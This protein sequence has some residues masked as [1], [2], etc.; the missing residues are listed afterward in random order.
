[1]VTLLWLSPA[2]TSAQRK[3]VFFESFRGPQNASLQRSIVAKVVDDTHFE[4]INSQKMKRFVR[5]RKAGRLKHDDYV[6][7]A[8]RY[9]ISAFVGGEV[10]KH[11]GGWVA[12]VEVKN[13]SDGAIVG[14]VTWRGRTLRDL[15][16]GTRGAA[17]KVRLYLL[18]TK[19]PPF[20]SAPVIKYKPPI[21][22]PPP[23]E[24]PPREPRPREPL[25]E[26]PS[27]DSPWVLE[28]ERLLQQTKPQPNP[29][30]RQAAER[31]K[32]KKDAR[33]PKGISVT[34]LAGVLSR[35]M[36][37]QLRV[38]NRKRTDNPEYEQ[39]TEQRTYQTGL[40][41]YP[42][43]GLHVEIYPGILLDASWLE[44]LG[45]VLSYRRGVLLS[46]SGCAQRE[47]SQEPCPDTGKIT[48]GT[49]ESEAYAGLKGRFLIP[50]GPRFFELSPEVGIG[51]F[52]YDFN[53]DDI[54]RLDLPAV[55]PPMIYRYVQLGFQV[56]YD[57]VARYF[58]LGFN[59]NYR[60]GLTNPDA[61][62]VWGVDT[63]ASRGFAVGLNI[64]S[65]APYLFDGAFLFAGGE[66][67]RFTTRFAGQA[68]CGQ[69]G[70]NCPRADVPEYQNNTPW[71]TFP[72]EQREGEATGKVTG[73]PQAPV[74]DTYIRIQ[75][76]LGW[77]FF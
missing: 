5:E 43:A 48:V 12:S 69:P 73:G 71:E 6:T 15:Q 58:N 40:P 21:E 76:G 50:D 52:R 34:L 24:P 3:R 9:G 37:G 51:E 26:H 36:V 74:N 39:I 42:E 64:R 23:R 53:L 75:L 41:G 13:G 72:E 66:W 22:E 20:A 55:I 44:P 28:D 61:N 19:P 46:S 57:F 33:K 65:E 60:P 77:A 49:L 35:D 7:F 45:V 29:L 14:V 27:G 8:K 70:G 17:D 16:T 47:N 4:R 11:R 59:F 31:P 62:L 1:V 2:A 63:K 67:F 56:R 30:V 38:Y 10:G 25:E 32:P 68:G 18:A 54:R